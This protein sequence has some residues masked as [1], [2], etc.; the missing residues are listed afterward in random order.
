VHQP[1]V[2]LMFHERHE[3]G[4]RYEPG[5]DLQGDQHGNLVASETFEL[6]VIIGIDGADPGESQEET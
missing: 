1:R 3:H 2:N 6:A 5:D 4:E